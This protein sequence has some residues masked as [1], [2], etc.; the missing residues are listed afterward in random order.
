MP[1]VM[2]QTVLPGH[3]CAGAVRVAAVCRRPEAEAVR[4]ALSA[5]ISHP[6]HADLLWL[7]W[8][9]WRA[10]GRAAMPEETGLS[11]WTVT[12]RLRQLREAGAPVLSS[13][14]ERDLMARGRFH[15]DWG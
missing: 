13:S 12:S 9:Q 14:Q 10:L 2:P 4:A 15:G 7:T 1:V 8:V 11:A 6:S 3:P 5:H